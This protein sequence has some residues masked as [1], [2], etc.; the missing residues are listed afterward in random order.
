MISTGSRDL[1]GFLKGYYNELVAFY[2][3]SGSGKTTISM[4]AG[5]GLAK[6]G[7]KTLFLDTQNGF[8]VERFIQLAGPNYGAYL[9][10]VFVINLNS[11]DEQTRKV[12][13]LVKVADNFDLIIIDSFN[14]HYR[15]EVRNN[16]YVVNKLMEKQIRVL[17]ELSKKKPIIITNQ[18]YT[19]LREK[20]E[21]MAGR[22]IIEKWCSRIFELKNNPR[23][24]IEKKPGKRDVK[25]EL[26]NN[27]VFII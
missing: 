7:K 25:F 19:D 12:C 1:D 20:K 13:D 11:F 27:G 21:V 2:G 4:I 6:Y 9:E 15:K 17:N 24:I 18:I 26:K 14:N 3:S 16:I 10:R 8:S 5:L 22:D 23:S